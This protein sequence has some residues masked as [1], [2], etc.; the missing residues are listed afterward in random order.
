[1]TVT[2]PGVSLWTK[3]A[4]QDQYRL[5]CPVDANKKSVARIAISSHIRNKRNQPLGEC[6]GWQQREAE[7]NQSA[8]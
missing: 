5:S 1:M 6:Y 8:W 3:R 4:H 2:D 7:K